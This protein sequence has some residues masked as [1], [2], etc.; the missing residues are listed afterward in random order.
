M[1]SKLLTIGQTA[2]MLGVSIQTLRRWDEAGKLSVKERKKTS[3]RHYFISD[4]ENYLM[5][6]QKDLSLFKI[7]RNW[8]AA[9]RDVSIFQDFYC[10]DISVFQARLTKLEQELGRVKKIGKI[11]IRPF[12]H[13]FITKKPLEVRMGNGKGNFYSWCVNLPKGFTILEFSIEEK[14]NINIFKIFKM[15]TSKIKGSIKFVKKN[16]LY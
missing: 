11:W 4:I 16:D 12:P 3:H 15:L 14:S 6:N 9:K 5:D 13:Y 10:Q 8:V 2:K 1:S 7:A